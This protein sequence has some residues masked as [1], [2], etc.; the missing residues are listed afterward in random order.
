MFVTVVGLAIGRV[1]IIIKYFNFINCLI[2]VLNSSAVD[3]ISPSLKFSWRALTI[4]KRRNLE[5]DE[6]PRQKLEN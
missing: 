6:A 2:T 3:F 4:D 5:L 1:F